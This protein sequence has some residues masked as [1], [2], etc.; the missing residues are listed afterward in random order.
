VK[1]CWAFTETKLKNKI[2]NLAIYMHYAEFKNMSVPKNHHYVSRCHQ[3]EFFNKDVGKIFIYDKILDNHYSKKST[4]HL[5]SDE[6]INSRTVQGDVDHK[7]LELE[8]KILIEDDF[9]SHLANI[10][11]FV[12][13]QEEQEKTYESL[14]YFTMLGVLGE[15]RHPD[16]KKSFENNFEKI[17]S[18]ILS[19]LTSYPKEKIKTLLEA[20]KKTKFSNVLSYVDTALRILE[21]MEPFDFEIFSIESSDHFILPDTTGFQIRGQ[22]HDYKNPFIS[23]ITQLG[24][25]LSDKMFVLATSKHLNSKQ[26]GIQ[27]IREDNSDVVYSINKDLYG[28]AYRAV[29]CKDSTYL[30]TFINSL[31]NDA[32]PAL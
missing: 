13:D 2:N 3:E 4:R 10:K 5:F 6:F 20:Q 11:N 9:P 26:S 15:L 7:Q 31:K 27:F 12:K 18:D 22:L 8:L 29:V 25:P 16:F 17:E 24:I 28:F 19:K 23:E 30:T 21:R 14:V 32:S 1:L